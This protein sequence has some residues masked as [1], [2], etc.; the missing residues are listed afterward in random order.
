MKWYELFTFRSVTLGFIFIVAVIIGFTN[1]DFICEKIKAEEPDT[2]KK[3]ESPPKPIETNMKGIAIQSFTPQGTIE[4]VVIAK[5]AVWSSNKPIKATEPIIYGFSEDGKNVSWIM[6]GDF[7]EIDFK[8]IKK[9]NTDDKTAI[10]D[11]V[12]VWGNTQ[13]DKYVLEEDRNKLGKEE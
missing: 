3:K 2:K 6:R 4:F 5:E 9:M 7:G 1:Y 10:I 11:Q 12:K 8:T 13:I